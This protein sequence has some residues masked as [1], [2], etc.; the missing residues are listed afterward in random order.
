M[1]SSPVKKIVA[2]IGAT[3]AQGGATVKSL[4]SNGVYAVRAIT[5]DPDSAKSKALKAL[6]AE[7]VKADVTDLESLKA[8]FKGAH[9]AFFVSTADFGGPPEP[10]MKQIQNMA[11]AAKASGVKHVVNSSLFDTQKYV[12]E[13]SMPKLHGKYYVPHFESKGSQIPYVNERVPTTTLVAAFY[14][15]NF[16]NFGMGPQPDQEGNLAITFPL[17]DTPMWMTAAEDI[18]H[19]A[20]KLFEQ[21]ETVGE[22]VG[23]GAPYKLA[24]VAALFEKLINK[25]VKYNNIDPTI[26]AKFPFPGADDMANMF[27]FYRD[28]PEVYEQHFKPETH[29]LKSLDSWL[30]E[31]KA[32]FQ[33]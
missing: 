6:G 4:L 8:A 24:D 31:N 9:G 26:Y 5:R 2:V 33:K 15:D 25:P 20:A 22:I 27:V 12:K 16:I 19:V 32:A 13:G 1:S 29:G 17:G 14:Y 23:V 21:P 7:V 30:E 18:G 28:V 11:D 10:E 3:G